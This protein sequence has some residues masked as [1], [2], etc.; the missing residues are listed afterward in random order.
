MTK[1][2]YDQLDS[3]GRVQC[4]KCLSRSTTPCGGCG[5]PSSKTGYGT[6]H[7]NLYHHR[8]PEPTKF[9]DAIND[10]DVLEQVSEPAIESTSD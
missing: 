6:R 10:P 2:E 4:P 9:Y 1:Q 3:D 7:I 5:C 8:C